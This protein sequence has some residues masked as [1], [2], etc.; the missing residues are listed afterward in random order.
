MTK[1]PN[2]EAVQ[3][4]GGSWCVKRDGKPISYHLYRDDAKR[5]LRDAKKEG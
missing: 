4:T 2:L 3:I 5:K 1:K